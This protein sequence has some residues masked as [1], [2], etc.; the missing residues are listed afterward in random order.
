MKLFTKKLI[1]VIFTFVALSSFSQTTWTNGNGTNIWSDPLNWSTALVP[2]SA[3]DVTFNGTSSANCTIDQ[4]IQI[5]NLTITAAY[6]GIIN[7]TTGLNRILQTNDFNQAGGTFISTDDTYNVTGNMTLTGGTFTHNGGIVTIFISS[8]VSLAISG[9]FVFNELTLTHPTPVVGVAQR[10][11][12]FGASASTSTLN[13]SGTN[14]LYG[15]TGAIT[16]TSDL[17]INGTNTGSPVSNTGAFNFTGAGP[18]VIHGSAGSGRNKIGNVTINTTGSFAVIS[19]IS[20]MGTWT[21]SNIG[22]FSA[23]TSTVHFAGSPA[24]IAAGTTAATKAY[25]DNTNI[26]TGTTLGINNGS[27][28]DIGGNFSQAG[29][30]NANTSLVSFTGASAHAV[31]GAAA[32]STFN[33]IEKTGA[34]SLAFSHA[35]N[36]LDSLKISGGSVN[37][38]SMTLKSTSALKAR[39]AEITGGG[40][41]S[42]NMTVETFIPGGS[43]DWAVLGG[44]GVSG[45]TFNSWYPTIPMA[46]EGSATGVTSASGQY[47]ESVQGWIESDAYGYDTTITVTSPITTGKG[48]W[49]F[50][51]TSLASSNAITTSVTGPPVTSAQSLPL[52]NSAQAGSCLLANPFA[53]PISWDRIDAANPG[54]TTGEIY[55]YNADLGLTTSYV[56]GISTPGGAG[57]ATTTIPMG[58]GFYVIATGASPLS[59]SENAK[60]AYNTGSNPLLKTTATSTIGSVLRLNLT[61]GTYSDG[62]AIR[63]HSNG[64]AGFDN[65]LDAKKYFDSPG[66]AGYPGVWTKRTT[67]STQSG[68]KDYSINSLPYAIATNA[69]IPVLVKVY[70]SGQ[71][72]IS[73]S[74]IS[75]LALGTC[76]TLKDKLLNI[77]HDLKTSDYVF[78]INDTTATARFELTVCANITAGINNNSVAA[79]N[80]FVKQDRNGVYVDLNFESNTKAYITANNILGQQLM[81]PKQVECVSGRYYLDLNAKEQIIMVSVIANEKRHT[82]KIFVQ[83][84]N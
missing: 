51:G 75:N 72:T 26:L 37:V 73:A 57:S 67:I 76:V 43:T 55:I 68:G 66:Y 83:Q 74:G 58:Q 10:N 34:G 59:I 7:G 15:Y 9:A 65:G 18:I 81:T 6:A 52:S 69:V 8:G 4:D 48:Y 31:N 33:A 39:L 71:H 2:T 60:V 11:L 1:A 24:A 27:F 45:L 53:S 46:I 38:T 49:V 25:F 28:V 19:Q 82:Q 61:N 21:S 14:R 30:F 56:G 70:A 50:V 84:Q 41:V 23:G 78:N 80:V 35:T 36:I 44:S 20:V 3:D 77:T 40:S 22:S 13:L 62:T 47:F 32:L 16:I 29:T 17:F 63:F 12:N 5:N 79:E 42:G 64:T 54:V